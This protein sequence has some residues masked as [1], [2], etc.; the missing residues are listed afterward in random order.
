M[1]KYRVIICYDLALDFEVM[2]ED[3]D[4]AREEAIRRANVLSDEEFVRLGEPYE[5]SVE[6]EEITEEKE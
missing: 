2:A 6:V 5:G 3:E 1:K 4:K